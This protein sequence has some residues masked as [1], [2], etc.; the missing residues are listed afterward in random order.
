MQQDYRRKRNIMKLK[1]VSEKPIEFYDGVEYELTGK[2]IYC[3]AKYLDDE[4][5]TSL[6]YVDN[7]CK[8]EDCNI[9]VSGSCIFVQHVE[10]APA[11]T[12]REHYATIGHPNGIQD[13]YIVSDEVAEQV[14]DDMLKSAS[15][16]LKKKNTK[17]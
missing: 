6:V 13:Y 8:T 5:E 1:T 14:I 4:K 11:I 2:W 7:A 12:F 3:E 10:G 17:R 15:D 9:I 16:N